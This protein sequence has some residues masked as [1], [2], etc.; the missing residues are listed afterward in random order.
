MTSKYTVFL[1]A[2]LRNS[3]L[4][5]FS[6][7]MCLLDTLH[8]FVWIPKGK[9]QTKRRK[10]LEPSQ[11]FEISYCNLV[12]YCLYWEYNLKCRVFLIVGR[13]NY[14]ISGA[15]IQSIQLPLLLLFCISAAALLAIIQHFIQASFL[16]CCFRFRTQ[17]KPLQLSWQHLKK[18]IIGAIA[19]FIERN[20]T[21][22]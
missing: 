15:N 21:R 4:L 5:T 7:W 14:W 19:W 12:H 20:Q 11:N 22:A 9:I 18:S 6:Q 3:C 16:R 17:S 13:R 1:M 10:I 2:S 8:C